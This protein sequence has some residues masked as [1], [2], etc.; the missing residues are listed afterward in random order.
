MQLEI[1]LDVHPAI[2]FVKGQADS[3][4]INKATRYR[5]SGY[6]YSE[7]FKRRRWDGYINLY[8]KNKRYFPTGLLERVK[9]AL[10]KYQP[11]YK[12]RVVDRRPVIATLDIKKVHDVQLEGIEPRD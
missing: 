3:S 12:I 8:N 5:K 4:V 6:Q 10:K 2:T 1:I 7:Q 11:G 9:R